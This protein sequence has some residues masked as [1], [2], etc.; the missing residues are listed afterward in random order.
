MKEVEACHPRTHTFRVGAACLLL[1]N[2]CS[3]AAV[4][5]AGRWAS[6]S[7]VERYSQRIQL[8]SERVQG[9]Q[10]ISLSEQSSA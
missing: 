8:A 2:G 7:M 9:L 10:W 6:D 4:R 1:Q 5:W 3:H